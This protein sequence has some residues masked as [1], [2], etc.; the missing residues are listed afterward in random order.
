MN[1]RT[2]ITDAAPGVAGDKVSASQAVPKL[3]H[4][5]AS[6]G[7]LFSLKFI[8]LIL[9]AC[10]LGL[11]VMWVTAILFTAALNA[12]WEDPSK[13]RAVRIG[14]AAERYY[15]IHEAWPDSVQVLTQPDPEL[16][17]RSYLSQDESLDPWGQPYQIEPPS[18]EGDK[19]RVWTMTPTGKR[20]TN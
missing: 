12:R 8:A 20:I 19:P 16:G 6:G 4:P 5:P 14:Q 11:P 17:G 10:I 7:R 13:V 3:R 15:L 9:F 18:R 1:K 2:E